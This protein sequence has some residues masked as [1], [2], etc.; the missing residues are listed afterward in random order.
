MAGPVEINSFDDATTADILVMLAEYKRKVY[1]GLITPETLEASGTG[2]FICIVPADGDPLAAFE[3]SG[4]PPSIECELWALETGELP[5]AAL[6][7]NPLQLPGGDPFTEKV[8]NVLDA[9]FAP[10]TRFL[11]INSRHGYFVAVGGAGGGSSGGSSSTGC[12]CSCLD[13]GD[14]EVEGII[15]TSKWSITLPASRFPISNGFVLCPAGT[16]IVEREDGDTNWHLDMGDSLTARYTSGNDATA[17]S[18][19]AGSLTMNYS[20][21][22]AA[23]V[24]LCVDG[25]SIPPEVP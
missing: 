15:T 5:A 4:E 6:E 11:A 16:Y 3:G 22:S 2:V 18:V 9:E 1:R 23:S 7:L 17:D 8:Y 21:G 13:Q 12:T 14:I 25:S 20:P 19:L 10:G 24:S